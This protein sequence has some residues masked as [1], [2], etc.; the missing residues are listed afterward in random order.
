MRAEY[1]FQP[2]GGTKGAGPRSCS[3][4]LRNSLG[5]DINSYLTRQRDDCACFVSTPERPEDTMDNLKANNEQP[6][7]HLYPSTVLRL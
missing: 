2:R 6:V 1:L 3:I 7:T 4:G 5:E